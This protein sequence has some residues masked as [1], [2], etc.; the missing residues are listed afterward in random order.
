MN[1]NELRAQMARH[2]DNNNALAKA[3]GKTPASISNKIKGIRP[4]SLS[5]VQTIITRYDLSAEQTATIFFTQKVA[6]NET[7]VK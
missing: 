4:F 6:E 3:L 7:K 2:G 5:E 1:S